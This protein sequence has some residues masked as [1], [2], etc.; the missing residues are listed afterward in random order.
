MTAASLAKAVPGLWGRGDFFARRGLG[1]DFLRGRESFLGGMRAFF[2][3]G[4]TVR[5]AN[6]FDKQRKG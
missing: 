1:L 3:E 5:R 6:A 2:P 4:L